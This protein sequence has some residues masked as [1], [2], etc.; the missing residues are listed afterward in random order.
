M[1]TSSG[2]HVCCFQLIRVP[3]EMQGWIPACLVTSA[4]NLPNLWELSP[5][6]SRPY[7][8]FTQVHWRH[9]RRFPVQQEAS[10]V[11]RHGLLH[12]CF[13]SHLRHLTVMEL[14]CETESS[15]VYCITLHH[16][17]QDGRSPAEEEGCGAYPTCIRA[18]VHRSDLLRIGRQDGRRDLHPSSFNSYPLHKQDC[19]TAGLR[20]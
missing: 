12:S 13:T 11:V 15:S 4:Q 1:F 5:K 10:R 18:L 16:H 17:H 2:K 20:S 8:M 6:L 9:T 7:D 3:M 14:S 19:L